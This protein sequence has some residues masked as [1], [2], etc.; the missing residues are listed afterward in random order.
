M[1]LRANPATT[2]A[3]SRPWYASLGVTMS[4]PLGAH[5]VVQP[6][7]AHHVNG[8]SR[9]VLLAQ[10]GGRCFSRGDY[11]LGGYLDTETGK[12]FDVHNG[13]FRGVIRGQGKTHIQAAQ[14]GK[15]IYQP[16][17]GRFAP[18]EDAVHIQN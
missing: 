18:P 12:L 16:R 5:G 6:L 11:V 7:V 3:V 1:A 10:I 17:H 4:K 8:R 9:S 15:K 2:T 13:R 14:R